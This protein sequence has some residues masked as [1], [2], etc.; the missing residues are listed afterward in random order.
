MP[1]GQELS[2]QEPG[3]EQQP[4]AP[5]AGTP[6]ANEHEKKGETEQAKANVQIAIHILEQ[7]LPQLGTDSEEGAVVLKAL[8]SLSKSFAGKKSE[9]L[10]AAEHAQT[11]AG[12]PDKIRQQVMKEMGAGGGLPQPGM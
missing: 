12:M 2:Q 1:D 9:D 11:M 4:T 10:V 6:A 3:Q 8:M 5:P 7:A